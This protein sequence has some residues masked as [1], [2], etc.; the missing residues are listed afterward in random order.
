L[1]SSLSPPPLVQY[2][3]LLYNITY[4][5]DDIVTVNSNNYIC[6]KNYPNYKS[7]FKSY[8]I[9]V[10]N[11]VYWN[12][13]G[14]LPTAPVVRD[15]TVNSADPNLIQIPTMPSL[16]TCFVISPYNDNT[17]AIQ[18][19]FNDNDNLI[20]GSATSAT[21]FCFNPEQI[22]LNTQL[23][24][25]QTLYGGIFTM[26][27]KNRLQTND[28]GFYSIDFLN[29]SSDKPTLGVYNSGPNKTI[30]IN[31]NS[32]LTKNHGT[33]VTYAVIGFVLQEASGGAYGYTST[34]LVDSS[35]S[36]Y[37]INTNGGLTNGSQ[38][39][40]FSINT[41]IRPVLSEFTMRVTFSVHSGTSALV[42]F[43]YIQGPYFVLSAN[44]NSLSVFFDPNKGI[45]SSSSPPS[46]LA[47]INNTFS[48]YPDRFANINL[49][50][51]RIG[52]YLFFKMYDEN[53]DILLN[54]IDSDTIDLTSASFPSFDLSTIHFFNLQPGL[55]TNS[56]PN[57]SN[58]GAI[59]VKNLKIFKTPYDF[60]VMIHDT[61]P[62]NPTNE[63]DIVTYTHQITGF[64]STEYQRYLFAYDSS[65]NAIYS[66]RDPTKVWTL[67]SGKIILSTLSSPSNDSQKWAI[68]VEM[69]KTIHPISLDGIWKLGNDVYDIRETFP[70]S[71]I[72]KVN[73]YTPTYTGSQQCTRTQN[74]FID[75]FVDNSNPYILFD[76]S[77]WA[78]S[79]GL[80]HVTC[81]PKYFDLAGYW[82]STTTD[83]VLCFFPCATSSSFFYT[84]FNSNA[85]G[86]EIITPSPLIRTGPN[87]F[88]IGLGTMIYNNTPTAGAN[89]RLEIT[90]GTSVEYF[91]HCTNRQT[92][93]FSAPQ[94]LVDYTA[95]NQ[96][97]SFTMLDTRSTPNKKY[98]FHFSDN[99]YI[100]KIDASSTQQFPNNVIG[101]ETYTYTDNFNGTITVN[102]IIM[103][104]SGDTTSPFT[105]PPVNFPNRYIFDRSTGT[106]QLIGGSIINYTSV[107]GTGSYASSTDTISLVGI[108][109][110]TQQ[111]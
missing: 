72:S 50:M 70:Q 73:K 98:I 60:K 90:I 58:F 28:G 94:P 100:T 34:S 27:S 36:T 86:R 16:S 41:G 4:Q 15:A 51:K 59:T 47:T 109:N 111:F 82:Y 65:T 108:N 11:T 74:N 18:S 89:P 104:A 78:S 88:I 87:N 52:S 49:E 1:I 81:I 103:A 95:I 37:A 54:P 106:G 53:Y 25:G 91:T 38:S 10:T 110:V 92:T 45:T 33:C 80:V 40:W 43:L 101:I 57:V 12:Y 105:R 14:T 96:T 46:P 85:G 67:S 20:I 69:N 35:S 32:K 61:D 24:S 48:L 75:N 84:V 7:V 21:Y 17:Q 31:S 97:Y 22:T 77:A 39:D 13:I 107:L 44:S 56:S 63:T 66:L 30:T 68:L 2:P 26:N 42:P 64:T 6:I 8:N 19:T 9:E 5:I 99:L 29:Q 93:S 71:A 3:P 83:T 79:L 62:T 102:T 76:F 23:P 55:Y